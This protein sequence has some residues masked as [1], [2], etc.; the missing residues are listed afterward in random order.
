MAVSTLGSWLHL[1][2]LRGID[3]GPD[4]LGCQSIRLRTARGDI[5]TRFCP[6]PGATRAVILVGGV[7]G[8]FDSPAMGLYERLSEALPP[9]GLSVLRVRYR[10]SHSLEESV[11]DL[12]AGIQFL[13]DR[14]V[15]H[16]GLV[17][18]S[19]GGAV[20]IISATVSPEVCGVVTLA[21]QSH[22]TEGVANVSPRALLLIHGVEDEIL[23]PQSS[24]Y[25]FKEARQPKQITLYEGAT[26]SLDEVA[27]EI[28]E[29][30]RTWLQA[31]IGP[32]QARSEQEH[33]P[34]AP[35]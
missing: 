1:P 7:G 22:G 5:E 31:R 21:T 23:R 10:D 14:R 32:R 9:Q 34:S 30:V 18:H 25:V 16:I 15:V 11:H 24:V 33:R 4:R 20:A 27:D 12:L 26:H 6:S 8:G 2:E 17:G 19:M 3:V 13:L 29:Q 28:F 35:G